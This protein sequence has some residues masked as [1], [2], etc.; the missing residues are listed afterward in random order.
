MPRI[1]SQPEGGNLLKHFG[2]QLDDWCIRGSSLGVSDLQWT[3][4]QEP[5]L[6]TINI[7]ASANS[8]CLT[9]E[10]A[11]NYPVVQEYL[12]NRTVGGARG[13]AFSVLFYTIPILRFNNS[14]LCSGVPTDY[15]SFIIID[16]VKPSDNQTKLTFSVTSL[17]GDVISESYM[18]NACK[19][20]CV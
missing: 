19:C 2:E 17:P 8:S 1:K 15:L 12:Q 16:E 5:N 11:T 4:S 7:S 3:W 14:W 10:C 18:I 20:T 9:C 13:V 6:E